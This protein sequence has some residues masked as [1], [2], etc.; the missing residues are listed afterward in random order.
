[1]PSFC[2]IYVTTLGSMSPQRVPIST[3]AN[4]VRPMLVSTHLPPS[5]A[6]MLLPLPKWQVTILISF[7]SL[8]RYCA[9]AML[10]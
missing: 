1:M 3:P 5:T 9:A 2:S 4:G 7:A 6:V 10:T 8:P